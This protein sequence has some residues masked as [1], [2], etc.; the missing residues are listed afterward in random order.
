VSHKANGSHH[1]HRHH[2]RAE[3]AGLNR[4]GFALACSASAIWASLVANAA[5]QTPV[6]PPDFGGGDLARRMREAAGA[7]LDSLD[8][9]SRKAVAFPIASNDRATWSNLPVGL[10]ARVG[11]SVGALNDASRRRVHAL[12]RASTSSQGYLKMAEIMRHDEL[13]RAFELDYLQ[14]NPPRPR[15]G[16]AA[17]ESMG[18]GNYWIA[19]F[20]DPRADTDWAWLLTGHHLGAS[21]TCVGAQVVAAP[22]FLGSSP[23]EELSGLNAGLSALGHEALR[24]FELARSLSPLQAKAA[25][26]SSDPVFSDVLSGIG[27]R[28]SLARFEGIPASELDAPQQRL[29]RALVGEYVGNADGEATDRHL[30]AIEKA[31]WDKLH[32]S[33]R[34]RVDA[35]DSPF[36]YRVHGPRLIIEFAVQEPNHFHTIMRDP[37]NDYG[38]D[39]LGLHYEEH[40]GR[41]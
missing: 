2:P 4:R 32:F 28:N 40:T 3:S 19:L 23:V 8:E 16:R 22:L 9:T 39:W 24:G 30:E 7:F 37:V 1:H 29:L 33:W 31:G 17:V 35:L 6:P 21:F 27:R 26:L 20:G 18:S 34:G 25:V 11:V 36:Y 38:V 10:T 41:D 15:A 5:A 12:L 14:H 13:L